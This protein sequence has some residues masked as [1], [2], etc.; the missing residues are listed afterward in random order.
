MDCPVCFVPVPNLPRGACVE[1]HFIAVK[2]P[3]EV[4]C[5]YYVY[6][7]VDTACSCS[8]GALYGVRDTVA[9]TLFEIILFVC[10][11]KILLVL[12]TRKE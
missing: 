10:F 11:V 5:M 6:I 7:Y 12:S 3:Q 9:C 2:S 1:W 8:V 4:T